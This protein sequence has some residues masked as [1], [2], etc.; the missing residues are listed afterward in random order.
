L[1]YNFP[2]TIFV[3]KNTLKKQLAHVLSEAAEVIQAHIRNDGI[4]VEELEEELMDLTHSLETFW[5]KYE[6]GR[7]GVPSVEKLRAKVERKNRER[8]YYDRDE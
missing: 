2:P 1:N 3:D 5:R 7:L 8:N 4:M 6:R